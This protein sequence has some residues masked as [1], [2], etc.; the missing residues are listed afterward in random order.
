MRT[1]TFVESWFGFFIGIQNQQSANVIPKW[2]ELAERTMDC[3]WCQTVKRI[4][5]FPIELCNHKQCTA[6]FG[7]IKLREP[8]KAQNLKLFAFCAF[9]MQI[10]NYRA[11]ATILGNKFSKHHKEESHRSDNFL[12]RVL[13]V[14]HGFMTGWFSVWWFEVPFSLHSLCFVYV[15]HDC[16]SFLLH[17]RLQH[18]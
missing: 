1:K 5:R 14:F 4:I 8:R 2:A 15:F 13:P 10:G 9:S 7:A 11:Y 3:L 6:Q 18:P 12:L 17:L 16:E